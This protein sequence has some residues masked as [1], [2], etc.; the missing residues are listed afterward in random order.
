MRATI[1]EIIPAS[2]AQAGCLTE[3]AHAAK[4]HWGYPEHWIRAWQPVLTITP[5]QIDQQLTC[6]ATLDDQ[7]VGFYALSDCEKYVSLEHLWVHPSVMGKGV[8]RD[9]FHHA[10]QQAAQSGICVLFIESD[11]HA[12]GFYRRMGARRVGQTLSWLEGQARQLPFL[13]YH[14]EPIISPPSSR[15][16]AGRR[17]L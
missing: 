16:R 14:H 17:H 5:D 3:I 12:E 11:P 10:V 4:R 8:G 7:P 9:L 2:P 13:I 1:L 6:V 15:H